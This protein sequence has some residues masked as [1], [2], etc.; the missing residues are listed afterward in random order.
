MRYSRDPFWLVARFGSKCADCGQVIRKGDDAFYYPI[1][2]RILGKPCG[3]A[4]TASRDFQ[5]HAY[6]EA[7]F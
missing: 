1:G 6:D 4:D 2:K 7:T 5:A 3:H